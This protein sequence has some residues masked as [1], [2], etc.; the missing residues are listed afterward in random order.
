MDSTPQNPFEL[1]LQSS[2]AAKAVSQTA[3]VLLRP[4]E[5]V[6]G[7]YKILSVIGTGGMGAVYRVEQLFLRKEFALKT[8]HTVNTTDLKIRRFQKEAQLASRLDHEN[9]V[10]AVDYGLIDGTQPFLIMDLVEGQTLAQY[11]ETHGRMPVELAL[12]TFIPICFAMAHAHSEGVIHRD[13]KPGNIVLTKFNPDSKAVVPKVVDFGIAKLMETEE[14]TLTETGQ[15]FGT[16]L[17]MSPEQTVGSHV[18]LRSD[19]YSLGCVFFEV[20]TG[21]PPFKGETLIQTILQHRNQVSDSLKKAALGLDFPEGLEQIVA[22]M[23][24]KDPE[25]RYQDC[26]T[27]AQDLSWLLQGKT[28]N[29]YARVAPNK[30]LEI[31]DE[32][33]KYFSTS[34]LLT[35]LITAALVST[36]FAT[37]W[38][39]LNPPSKLDDKPSTH[40]YRSDSESVLMSAVLDHKDDMYLYAMVQ[41]YPNMES[42]NLHHKQITDEGMQSC[43]RL[44]LLR[45]LDLSNCGHVS[46][47]GIECLAQLPLEQLNLTGTDVTGACMSTLVRIPTLNKLSFMRTD[48]DDAGCRSL[49]LLPRL[50][51]LY[52]SET[53]VTG[54]GLNDLSKNQVV[55]L[56][57]DSCRIRSALH[58][59][60]EM[61]LLGL[62][63][64]RCDITNSDLDI[65]LHLRHIQTLVL[66]RNP[67]NDE[68]LL[69]LA[70]LP[71]LKHLSVRL[72]NI[73][74]QGAAKF[75]RLKP[76]CTLA[77]E[78]IN[79]RL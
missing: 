3:T 4:G 76:N 74:A 13:I 36:C 77:I 18:D 78:D 57:L 7:R 44:H 60:T 42:L 16:P 58:H 34:M 41:N 10:Q 63:L 33:K 17:Y 54:K 71:N 23:L 50:S 31:L 19:I 20:L 38:F 48:F 15:V 25:A 12:R 9:L 46:D 1:T 6:A 27:L 53:R 5:I 26:L 40:L 22:K 65:L 14:Q 61:N 28:E 35:A 43:R 62:S 24:A 72:C 30:V 55:E 49:R 52:L 70:A 45:I 37:I 32:P 2:E 68:G 47:R 64:S 21:V 39:I 59:L 56:N 69:K 29:I 11:L 8:L 66:D 75:A 51:V 79:T 67:I 73:S